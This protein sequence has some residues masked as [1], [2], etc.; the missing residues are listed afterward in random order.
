MA[1]INQ[2]LI[3]ILHFFDYAQNYTNQSI[4]AGPLSGINGIDR[5]FLHMIISDILKP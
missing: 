2:F 4:S 5:C 3:V 1:L